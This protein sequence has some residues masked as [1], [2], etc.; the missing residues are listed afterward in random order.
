MTTNSSSNRFSTFTDSTPLLTDRAELRDRAARDGYLFFRGLLPVDDVMQL[1]ADLLDVLRRHGW[2]R[3]AGGP[4][5]G[6]VEVETLNRVPTEEMRT[7]IGVSKAIYCDVQK[8]ESAHAL[9]HHP[10]LIALYRELFGREVLVHPRHII[11]MVTPHHAMTPT[12]AH[13]DFPLIQ[14]TSNTWT[15]W[16]PVGDCGSDLGGLAVLRGSHR[17]GFVPIRLTSGA[18]GIAAQLCPGEEDWVGGDYTVGD[19]LTFPSYTIHRGTP[20]RLPSQVRLSLDI[21]FQPADEPVEAQSLSPHCELSWE[22]IYA[23]WDRED[24]KY[25]W[26]KLPLD[27]SAWD[28]QYVKPS[29]RIC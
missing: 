12:P 16:F 13:Q 22:Q 8:L 10:N 25:Y 5:D 15:C 1:R 2:S 29:R 6:T 18:G 28:D 19:V 27:L 23:D 4:L 20:C 21:R 24:L 26:R 11:R 9:P 17:N 7:D 14:G 3:P